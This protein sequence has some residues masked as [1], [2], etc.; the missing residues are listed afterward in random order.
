MIVCPG[1]PRRPHPATVVYF[2]AGQIYPDAVNKMDSKLVTY[3]YCHV[4]ER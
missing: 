4:S 1:H 2:S 3:L